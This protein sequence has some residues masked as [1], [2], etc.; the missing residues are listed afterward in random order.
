MSFSS[1]ALLYS[2][3]DVQQVVDSNVDLL[4]TEGGAETNFANSAITQAELA[5]I[6]ANGTQVAGY[7]NMSVTDDSRPYWDA[8]WTDDGTDTGTVTAVAP[9][10]LT[11]QPSNEFGF[12][13]DYTDTAWQDIVIAQAVDLV[14]SGF[15][16]VFLDD[17]Q[18]YYVDEATG[19]TTSQN[20][21]DMMEF[22]VKI[23]EA[24]KEVNPDAI[25]ISNG[26]PYVVTDA[27]DGATSAASVN[28][29][30]SIDGMLLEIFFGIT[31]TETAAIEQAKEYIL[32][33][34]DVLALEYGGTPYQN[35]LFQQVAEKAGFLSFS[36]SDAS[37]SDFG[38]IADATTGDDNLLGTGLGDYIDAYAGDDIIDAGT[39][40]D[41]VAG[42]VGADTMDGGEGSDYLNYS[43][44]TASVSVDMVTGTGTG[45]DAAG[46][47]FTG[48]ENVVGSAFDD[49]ITG[50]ASNNI[51]KGNGGADTVDGGAGTDYLN[52]N[53]SA[54]GVAVNLTTGTGS[55]GDAEGDVI[56]GIERI[57]G[58]NFDDTLT[59]DATNNLF[60]GGAGADV[61]DGE[62]GTDWVSYRGSSEAVVID[63]EAGTGVG[64]DADG[65][66]LTNIE[67]VM[68]SDNFDIL[69]G[70]SANNTF[71]G[72]DGSDTIDGGAGD[73]IALYWADVA[74]FTYENTSTGA[75]TVT[76]ISTG[77]FD[78]LINIETLQFNDGVTIDAAFVF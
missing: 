58:S 75:W 65:D 47:S 36:S 63:L 71:V 73:D 41:V 53:N 16:G 44:S 39:G 8:S 31:Q 45:G 17:F 55:G 72:G 43:N 24:I 14:S 62:E 69:I 9:E 33:S 4:V 21:T 30:E 76:E 20:A 15:D 49:V 37:Y 67:R 10:W 40:V 25:L 78:T 50:D 54:E 52:Y 66:T 48:F 11:D 74:G 60:T 38:E 29:L 22:A 6:Q 23:D 46:D 2:G 34:A 13:V 51:I 61:L 27:V 12:V 42:G 5:T 70:D 56:T 18:Q 35:Y 64:G 57:I 59:G 68:G 26:N 3:V 7:I 28:Y 19:L 1:Y 77:Y 32:G